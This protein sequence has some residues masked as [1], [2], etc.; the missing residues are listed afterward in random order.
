MRTFP[1]MNLTWSFVHPRSAHYPVIAPGMGKHCHLGTIMD[2]TVRSEMRD[3]NPT[4][5]LAP[6]Q[7]SLA[8]GLIVRPNHLGH[9]VGPGH[10]RLTIV[11]A[12]ENAEP[13]EQCVDI[14]LSG[15][16]YADEDRML[17]DGIGV[18]IAS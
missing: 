12:A 11:V 2:P 14:H 8:F 13:K 17:R 15:R 4:L 3:E 6:D 18:S 5:R 7:T 16:W 1:P 9:I 10:Y